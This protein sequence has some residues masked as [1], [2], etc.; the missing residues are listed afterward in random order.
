MP[1]QPKIK[2]H[3]KLQQKFPSSIFWSS[4]NQCDMQ[5]FTN[6]IGALL[7]VGIFLGVLLN[8]LV[9]QFIVVG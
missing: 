3:C 9:I 8:H 4:Q 5:M 1:P 2:L 6:V 7:I